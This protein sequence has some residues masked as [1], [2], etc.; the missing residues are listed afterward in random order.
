MFRQMSGFRA[1]YHALTLV[2]VAEFN[3]WR[4]L[5]Y[6]S[7]VTIQGTRQFSEEKAKQ[8]AV[9]VARRYVHEHKQEDLPVLES[10]PW[11]PTSRDD[12]LVW[13]A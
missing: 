2:V 9:E 6:G 4:V 12:W 1:P 13:T 11:V 5:L 10:I 3:E 7:G 8:H